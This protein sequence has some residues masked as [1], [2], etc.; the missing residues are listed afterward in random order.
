VTVGRRWR[1]AVVAAVVAPAALLAGCS[2]SGTSIQTPYASTTTSLEHGSYTEVKA[3]HVS[4]LGS[5]V[6]DGKGITLYMYATDVRG[7]PSRCYGICATQWPPYVLP[8]GTTKPT[9]G[10]GIETGLLGTVARSD[11]QLQVT[12]NGWPLYFWPPDTNPGMAT[13]QHLTNAGG[14]WYVVDPVT[15]DP[16]TTPT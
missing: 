6:V 9:A 4:G 11:G 16:I 5:V 15:G 13:G 1:P 3:G 7:Q 14:L 12:Y 10:P 2:S 8:R